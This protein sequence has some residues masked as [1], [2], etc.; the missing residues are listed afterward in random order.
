MKLFIASDIHGSSA[1]C[2]KLMERYE[3][4][5][6]DKVLLLGDI[7]YHGPRNDLPDLYAPKGVI[8]MLN[9]IAGEILCVCGNCDCDVDQMVLDFPILSDY[10][11]LYIDGVTIYATHGH[12]YNQNKPMKG[13]KGILLCGH[14]HVP[15]IEE[16]VDFTYLNPGSVS[17]PKKGSRHSYMVFENGV[18]VWKDVLS[19][20]VYQ[21]YKARQI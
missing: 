1:Y 3:E 10:S 21:E 15:C 13:A 14:T 17:I 8:E 6:P 7:L 11:F 20:E 16:Y 12:I 18:F 4:E 19:G 9:S 5:K 2:E